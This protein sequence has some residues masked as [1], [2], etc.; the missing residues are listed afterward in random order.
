[1]KGRSLTGLQDLSPEEVC[2]VLD[3]AQEQ[4]A[5]LARGERLRPVLDGMTV[6]MIFEKPSLRTR[7]SFEVA[8]RQLGGEPTFLGRDEV[9]LGLRETVKDFARV[10]SRYVD[11]LV[12]RVFKHEH[13]EELVRECSVPVINALSDYLHPCQG[14]ADALTIIERFDE[15][16]GAKVCFIGDGN[17]VA[18]SLANVCA[19]LGMQFAIASPPGYELDE[20]FV[21]GLKQYMPGFEIQAGS[22]AKEIAAGADVIYTDVWASMGQEEEAAERERAFADFQVNAD[23]MA[24]ASDRAIAMH[25]L[26]AHRGLEITD[27]V[28]D[29][30]QAAV[31]DQAEN[32]L[33]AQRALISLIM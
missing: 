16:N 26:P 23:L 4:K 19:A 2:L 18:R 9:G 14:L 25:C 1:M 29:G 32:R 30:P 11:I 5:R 6:G 15:V 22:N 8:A 20:A 33:H 24:V 31:Y 10:I 3:T 12:A 7:V 28:M 17:N 21:A 27:E 13:I